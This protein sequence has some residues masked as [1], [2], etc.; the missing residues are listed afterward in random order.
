MEE[1][2]VKVVSKQ[3]YDS[4]GNFAIRYNVEISNPLQTITAVIENFMNPFKSNLIV[5]PNNLPENL[6]IK[7]KEAIQKYDRPNEETLDDEKY[8]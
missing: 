2:E 8:L 3:T 6:N 1:G 5:V 7:I 4:E